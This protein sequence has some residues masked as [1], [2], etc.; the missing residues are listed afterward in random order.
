MLTTHGLKGGLRAS[1]VL[2]SGQNPNSQ[3]STRGPSRY[4]ITRAL[5]RR[6]TPTDRREYG[7]LGT[8]RQD[9]TRMFYASFGRVPAPRRGRVIYG[10]RYDHQLPCTVGSAAKTARPAPPHFRFGCDFRSDRHAADLHTRVIDGDG[11]VLMGLGLRRGC[12]VRRRR[13]TR[14]TQGV[15]PTTSTSSLYGTTEP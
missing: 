6:G 5:A 9:E 14:A 4:V 13:R 8:P 15:Y 1:S 11:V 7:S 10:F 3:K 12:R 2:V